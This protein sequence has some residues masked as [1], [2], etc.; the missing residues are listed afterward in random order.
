MSKFG[1]VAYKLQLPPTTQIHPVFHVSMLKKSVGAQSVS[2]SRPTFICDTS[3]PVEPALILDRRV[4]YKHGA[5]LTQV[6][7]QWIHLHPDNNMW[8][9]LP[10]L[11]TQFP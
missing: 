1:A 11:L 4:I 2:S 3:P 6:L 7:V 8:E 9:Y 10:D 5:P